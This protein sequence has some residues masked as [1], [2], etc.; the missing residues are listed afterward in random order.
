MRPSATMA[1]FSAPAD[2]PA[3]SR[4]GRPRSTKTAAT[5]ASYAPLAPPPESTSAMGASS[6]RAEGPH[7]DAAA[8]PAPSVRPSRTS[9][10]SRAGAVREGMTRLLQRAGL[11]VNGLGAKPER[12]AN[13]A[14]G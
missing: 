4:I 5:P 7:D 6:G 14:R 12:G 2:E 10:E 1:A 3:T 11:R 13:L 8:E 9:S